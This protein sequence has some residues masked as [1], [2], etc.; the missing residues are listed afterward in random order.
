MR[1][2]ISYEC[3][4]RPFYFS[5]CCS[6]LMNFWWFSHDLISKVVSH[7][8]HNIPF[9]YFYFHFVCIRMCCRVYLFMKIII[10]RIRLFL[11]RIFIK[12]DTMVKNTCHTHNAFYTIWITVN[13]MGQLSTVI[14]KQQFYIGS[15]FL[16]KHFRKTK[17]PPMEMR[18][19]H[20][21]AHVPNTLYFD[22]RCF[23]FLHRVVVVYEFR[24]EVQLEFQIVC[25]ITCGVKTTHLT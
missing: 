7:V 15:Y 23:L 14:S 12:H 19:T 10:T 5:F 9:P 24:I 18:T 20:A 8:L 11:F 22:C 1:P 16:L 13:D 21:N 2:F 25:Q 6:L 4:V 3:L 17:N